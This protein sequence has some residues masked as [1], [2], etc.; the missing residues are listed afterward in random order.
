MRSK[1]YKLHKRGT[2]LLVYAVV[3]VIS[4]I[5]LFAVGESVKKAAA[6]PITTIPN[7]TTK[8]NETSSNNPMNEI[9]SAAKSTNTNSLIV[10]KNPIY[11]ATGG[12]LGVTKLKSA[13]FPQEVESI[14]ENG[15]I[16]GVGKVTNLET[17]IFSPAG[18]PGFGHGVITTKD[19][20]VITWTAHD[21]SGT[22]SKNGTAIYRGLVIFDKANNSPTSKLAFLNNLEGSYVTEA[23]GNNQTRRIW[24]LK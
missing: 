11:Q 5:L 17:W 22:N 2:R 21:I 13:G 20:Q 16:N 7:N 18:S 24:K 8:I 19:R 14:F 23:S 4:L 10:N 9:T 6:A 3:S 12:T 1:N 15:T